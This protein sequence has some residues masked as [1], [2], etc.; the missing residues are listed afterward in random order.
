MRADRYGV[1]NKLLHCSGSL[2]LRLG[3][4]R[5]W[6][7][8]GRAEPLFSAVAIVSARASFLE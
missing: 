3:T 4:W 7:P 8:E 5:P 6:I 2:R 1:L